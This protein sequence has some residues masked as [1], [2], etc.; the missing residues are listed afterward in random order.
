MYKMYVKYKGN[1]ME[2]KCFVIC[3]DLL[4]VNFPYFEQGWKKPGFFNDYS[5]R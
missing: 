4:A 2:V 3:T 1:F 5:T